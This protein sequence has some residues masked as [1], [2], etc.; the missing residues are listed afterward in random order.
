[1]VSPM[2]RTRRIIASVGC[3]VAMALAT[4]LCSCM[5]KPPVA[6]ADSFDGLVFEDVSVDALHDDSGAW[7][8]NGQLRVVPSDDLRA[9]EASF[10]DGAA[11]AWLVIVGENDYAGTYPLVSGESVHFDDTSDDGM[12]YSVFDCSPGFTTT[13]DMDII[14][15]FDMSMP[16]DG[17]HIGLAE[18]LMSNKASFFVQVE[19]NRQTFTSPVFDVRDYLSDVPSLPDVPSPDL[20][21]VPGP[22][23]P[24]VDEPVTPDDSELADRIDK[25][26]ALGTAQLESQQYT[27]AILCL[28]C[29]LLVALIMV[30][31]WR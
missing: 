20:P 18:L 31:G 4:V 28:G 23:E 8:G 12:W 15:S 7:F 27:N 2:S 19:A 16:D 6:Y 13:E 11:S 25:W 17:S 3:F 24:D 30:T 1:M 22:D 14:I 5:L 29:G 9:L 26:L 21:D 10:D